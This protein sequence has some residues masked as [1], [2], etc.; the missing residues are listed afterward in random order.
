M[1]FLFAALALIVAVVS[2]PP[3]AFATVANDLCPAATDPCLVTAD[4]VITSDSTLDFGARTVIVKAGKT[5]DVGPGVMNFIASGF[6]LEPKAKLAAPG[7]F[8]S[9]TTTGAVE[10]Q[11]S[12]ADFARIDVSD[13]FGG[14]EV[15]I[16][17]QGPV[18]IGGELVAK[19]DGVGADGGDIFISSG[20]DILVTRPLT[21]KGGSDAGGGTIT[22]AAG[23]KL[24]ISEAFDASGGE[25]DGGDIDL[26]ANTNLTITAN[27]DL[28]MSGGSLSGSGGS[29]E[30]NSNTGNV[31][32]AGRINGTAGGSAEEG[33]GFGG[34]LDAT[35]P[36]GNVALLDDIDV[37][38]GDGGGAGD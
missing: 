28:D 14:G 22:L 23:G 26:S 25:F 8:I 30:L 36:L 34:T 10:I 27:G 5:L 4:H 2:S 35:A 31:S 33:G 9:I 38:G 15:D 29:V 19:G 37:P 6:R 20:A 11:G 13:T 17:A 21:G 16:E 1:H 24:D 12:G 18:G 7:G 32:F 3:K